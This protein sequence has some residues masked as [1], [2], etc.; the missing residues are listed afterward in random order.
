M[1]TP[2]QMMLNNERVDPNIRGVEA[3]AVAP[4]NRHVLLGFGSLT[5]AVI[6]AICLFFVTAN[7][8]ALLLGGASIAFAQG[9]LVFHSAAIR[10]PL[11]SL[12]TIGAL[13][14]L[15]LLF[16]SWRLRSAPSARWRRKPLEKQERRRVIIVATLS[17]LTLV[18]VATELILH[19]H[20]HGSSFARVSIP[21]LRIEPNSSSA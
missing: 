6:E 12:A 10:I 2:T 11:L 13:L 8:V 5:L 20:Y 9:V 18:F 4:K 14:N 16:N 3:G 7:G 17:I 1:Q 21:S 19:H 15:W